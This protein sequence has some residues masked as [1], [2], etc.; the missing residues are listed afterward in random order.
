MTAPTAAL[1][2]LRTSTAA[3]LAGIDAERWTDAAVRVPSLL[4]GWTRGHVLAHIARNAD[5]ITRTLSGALRGEIVARYPDG[6]AGRN[7]DIEAGSTRGCAELAADVRESADRLDR[8]FGAVADADGWDLP[9]EDRPARGYVLARWLEV[10]IHRVDLAGAYTAD[11]W[12]AEFVAYLLPELAD[13]LDARGAIALRIE[14]VAHGSVTAD[15][16]GRVWTSGDGD[17]IPVTGPDWALAAWLVGRP[18]AAAPVLN[19]MPELAPWR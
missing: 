10:E 18:Q 1:T 6:K 2:A 5:G 16:A 14:V 11:Q 3:L 8:L 19:P 15:L 12:P 9:T 7:A 13:S 17:R 4:P